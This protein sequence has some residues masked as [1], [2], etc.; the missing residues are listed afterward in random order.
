LRGHDWYAD[1]RA[2]TLFSHW[3]TPPSEPRRYNTHFFFAVAPP[4][5]AARADAHETHDGMWIEPSRALELYRAGTLR[6][7]YP[8]IKH[9]ER[10]SSFASVEDALRYARTKPVLTIMPSANADDFRIPASL[11]N[12]W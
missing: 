5:Q 7:V 12:E 9:L 10:L 6:L 2:L 3:I 11:E 4:N 1:A 8:T